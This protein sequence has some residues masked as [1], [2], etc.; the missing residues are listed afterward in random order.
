M[1]SIISRAN[2]VIQQIAESDKLDIVFQSDQVVWASPRIDITDKVI[3]GLEAPEPKP[4][5]AD[6]KASK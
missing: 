2:S 5:P 6:G 1:G 3:K 4:R